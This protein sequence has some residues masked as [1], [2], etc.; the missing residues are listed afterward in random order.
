MVFKQAGRKDPTRAEKEYV[1]Q[2]VQPSAMVSALS[3]QEPHIYAWISS[4]VFLNYSYLQY[5][6]TRGLA[7]WSYQ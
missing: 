1:Q 6:L 2:M 3:Y 4:G 5:I 7:T